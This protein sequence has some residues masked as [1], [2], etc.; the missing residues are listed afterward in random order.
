[1]SETKM[2]DKNSEN[3]DYNLKRQKAQSLNFAVF[4]E[5]MQRN[6]DKVSRKSYFK[7]TKELLK[8]YSLNPDV[9]ISN[10][11][12]VSRYL[13][14][15]SMLYK[16]MLMYYA[17][18][19]LYRYNIVQVKNFD[20]DNYVK[21]MERLS[22]FELAKQGYNAVYSCVRDGM[23]CGYMCDEDSDGLFMLPLDIEYVRIFGLT[24]EGQR[25]CYFNA[26]FFDNADNKEFIE[27]KLGGW[28]KVFVDGYK[29]YKKDG[30]N[31]Q[32]FRLPPE[33]TFC[34]IAVDDSM[35]TTPVPF[36]LPLFKALLDL[37]DLEDIIQNKKELENYK[38]ILNKIPLLG[39]TDSVDDFA[40]SLELVKEFEQ[41]L[42]ASV[43][44][45][46]GCAILP[47]TTVD[48]VSFENSNSTSD[49]DTLNQSIENLFSNAGASRL[50]IASGSSSN[51]V[52]LKYSLI[53]DQSN[54]WFFVQQ[55]ESWLR[56]YIKKNISP[57]YE[58]YIHKMS[59]YLQ[60]DY[61]SQKREL[62]TLGMATPMEVMSAINETPY[63]AYQKLLFERNLGIYDKLRTVESSYN[64]SNAGRPT[65]D[66]T[67]LSEEGQKTREGEKNLKTNII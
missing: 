63:L 46:I 32:W 19:F 7:Y 64:T 55:Y 12:E 36:W 3:S 33:K 42:E 2:I 10:I 41:L 4:N 38:L 16:K 45:L 24:K 43:P 53:N 34:M 47:G 49:T 57:D 59:W 6:V 17:S 40:V 23:F 8:Q 20:E 5:I 21:T 1:M 60:D 13:E 52:G 28:P 50:V 62:S 61:V 14:R 18:M 31:S 67:E 48:T 26:K 27:A 35:F 25:I 58:F 65:M 39:N 30:I 51:S 56:Y 9:N 11:R 15:N 22:Q 54:V 66:E 29:R 44:E 37:L